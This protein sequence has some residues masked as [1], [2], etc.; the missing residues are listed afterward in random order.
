MEPYIVSIIEL[1]FT[2]EGSDYCNDIL[3]LLSAYVTK[4]PSI[5]REMWFFY[6]CLFYLSVG[7]TQPVPNKEQY[8]QVQQKIFENF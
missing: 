4:I 7:V 3:Y 5:S 1:G 2:R 6:P 8:N